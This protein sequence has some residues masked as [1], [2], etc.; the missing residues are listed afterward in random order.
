MLF[1][2]IKNFGNTTAIVKQNGDLISYKTLILM[3]DLI[4]D[5]IGSNNK[6]L[7][8]IETRN[9]TTSIAAYLAC[10]I[11][12]HPVLLLNSQNTE[13]NKEIISRYQPNIVISTSNDQLALE[14]IN[15]N[16]ISLHPELTLL[17]ATSGSTGSPKLVKL[18]NRNITSNTESIIEY[19]KISV[20][21]RAITTLKFNYSYGLSILNTH[22]HIGA[23]IVLTDKSSTEVDFWH[24]FD[25]QKVTSFSGVPYNFEMLDSQKFD[26]SLYKHLRYI[27]QAGGKL[28]H[29][30]VNK[31]AKKSG[32]HGVEFFVMY[33]QTEAAPRVSYLPP[34]FATLYP[35]SIGNSIPGGSL[36]IIDTNGVKITSAQQAGELV[37]KGPNVMIGY[38]NNTA[39]LAIK[40][41]IPWLKTGDIAYY[42][43]NGLFTITGRLSRFAKPFGIRINL[44]DVEEF[45]NLKNLTSAV[46]SF[47]EKILVAVSLPAENNLTCKQLTQE[48]SA[49]FILPEFSIEVKKISSIPRL[50]NQKTDYQT[51]KKLFNDTKTQSFFSLFKYHFLSEVK[52]LLGLN[53]ESWSSVLNIYQHYFSKKMVSVDC[54]FISLAGDSMLYVQMSDELESYLGILPPN[55]HLLTINKLEEI[56]QHNEL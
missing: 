49:Q 31:F 40:E 55:W 11:N 36:S 30:L 43:E 52:H 5:D 54:S 4:A 8:F 50:N 21:D 48:M 7:V 28:S 35:G 45:L 44:D 27:T 33:G 20:K 38:A 15:G 29:P 12:N 37:Y 19:L 25:K 16:E 17:L 47:E 1:G 6:K 9:N 10:I 14:V 41:T 26:L 42:D 56:K 23:S 39:D 34:E 18:S 32:R 24:I 53:T 22:L 3:A 46:V 13:Q 2:Q 51:I